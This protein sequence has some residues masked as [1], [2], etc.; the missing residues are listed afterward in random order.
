MHSYTYD[1]KEENTLNGPH[2]F[3]TL[4]SLSLFDGI[5]NVRR[6]GW[7]DHTEDEILGHAWTFFKVLVI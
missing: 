2:P 5:S 6:F 4:L 3:F 1:A 7:V